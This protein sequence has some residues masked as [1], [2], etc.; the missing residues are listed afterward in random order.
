[1]VLAAAT[2]VLA[3][4]AAGHVITKAQLRST[5]REAARSIAAQTNAA[6]TRVL[7]CRRSSNHRG[8]CGVEARYDNGAT[9]CVVKVGIRLRRSNTRWRAGETACY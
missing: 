6:S 3:A 9:R 4:P 5:A 8:R 1:M 7:R 2:L